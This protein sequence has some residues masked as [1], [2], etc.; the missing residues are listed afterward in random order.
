MA[1]LLLLVCLCFSINVFAIG[2]RGGGGEGHFGGEGAHF[3]GEGENAGSGGGRSSE[4]APRGSFSEHLP[5]VVK[6]DEEGGKI[7]GHDYDPDGTDRTERERHPNEYPVFARGHVA[8]WRSAS[9]AQASE[10][11]KQH[12]HQIYVFALLG[13]LSV[14]AIGLCIAIF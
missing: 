6:A 1:R 7:A 2:G 13:V 11:A 9:D 4:S 5:G 8:G 14:L 12:V 10:V 3:G